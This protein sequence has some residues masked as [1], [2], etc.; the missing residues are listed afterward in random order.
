MNSLSIPSYSYEIRIAA[1]QLPSQPTTGPTWIQSLSN[2]TSIRVSWPK[3]A[4]TELPTTGYKLYR[5]GGNDGQFSIIYDGTHRPGQLSYISTGLI[6]GTFYRFKVLASN[7]ND[8]G[9]LSD[10]VLISAC[11]PPSGLAPP[12]RSGGTN[13][14]I[15]LEWT[16]PEELNGCPITGFNIYQGTALGTDDLLSAQL[17]YSFGSFTRSQTI[18]YTS[19]DTGNTYVYQLEVTNAVGSVKSGII[20]TALVGLPTVPPTGPQSIASETNTTQITVEWTDLSSMLNGGT[21]KALHLQMDGGGDE[22]YI[23][24]IGPEPT[25]LDQIYTVAKGIKSGTTYLFRYRVMNENGWGDFSPVTLITAATVPSSPPKPVVT[26]ATSSAIILSFSLSSFDGGAPLTTYQL[27]VND[28]GGRSEHTTLVT[29]YTGATLAYSFSSTDMPTIT[30]GSIWVFKFRVT[31]SIG[32]YADSW[33]ITVALA[34]SWSTPTAPY[35]VS[36]ESNETSIT[37]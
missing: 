29:G 18:T 34:D 5:D 23:D 24:L 26:S 35:Q 2:T 33:I 28:W 6:T 25:W 14:T 12:I 15:I 27:Y 7:F 4:D 17:I 3:V 10:E 1:A 31:N 22:N 13:T 16:P 32:D 21:L 9:S 36:D 37:L 11:M 30:S 20:E 19:S 8:D